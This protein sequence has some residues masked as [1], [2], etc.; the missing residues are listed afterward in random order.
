MF[1]AWDVHKKIPFGC[2]KNDSPR[3]ACNMN[4]LTLVFPTR[5]KKGA[6][7]YE[8]QKIFSLTT[9]PPQNES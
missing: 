1:T 4:I 6:W 8:N 7:K 2:L 3:L 9:D 5:W